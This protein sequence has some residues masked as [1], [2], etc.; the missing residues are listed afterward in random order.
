MFSYLIIEEMQWRTEGKAHFVMQIY[1]ILNIW[2][3]YC[4]SVCLRFLLAVGPN[5]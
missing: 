4:H 1:N 2:S 3:I 5:L